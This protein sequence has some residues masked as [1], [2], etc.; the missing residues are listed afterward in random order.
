MSQS[1]GNEV[2]NQLFKDILRDHCPDMGSTERDRLL[3]VLLLAV[4]G[5]LTEKEY[6]PIAN[7]EDLDYAFDIADNMCPN[8]VTPW[9]CNGPHLSNQTEAYRRNEGV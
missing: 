1:V 2:L 3:E 7:G 6:P 9:K 5:T 4:E 8:C